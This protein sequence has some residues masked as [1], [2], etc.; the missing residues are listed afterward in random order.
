M[1]HS[2]GICH[3]NS[4]LLRPVRKLWLSILADVVLRRDNCKRWKAL[5][6]DKANR[7]TGVLRKLAMRCNLMCID[8]GRPLVR[9][10]WRLTTN[11]IVDSAKTTNINTLLYFTPTAPTDRQ[12]TPNTVRTGTDSAIAKVT[13]PKATWWQNLQTNVLFSIWNQVAFFLRLLLTCA[14]SLVD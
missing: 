11:K 8:R 1:S 7:P 5:T 12:W 4:F 9:D 2:D 6:T 10:Y 3:K 13:K 14:A